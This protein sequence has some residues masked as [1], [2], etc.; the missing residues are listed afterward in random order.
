MTDFAANIHFRT[1]LE[2]AAR[3]DGFKGGYGWFLGRYADWQAFNS[4][5]QMELAD[6]GYDY[7]ECE[8]IIEIHGL[9]DLND[10][11]QQELFGALEV[12][13]LQ[14]RTLHLYREDDG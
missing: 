5:L 12:S 14:Y 10:G 13:P 11:E 7:L 8:Q 9:Q 1:R 6:L 2:S 4:A 3:L